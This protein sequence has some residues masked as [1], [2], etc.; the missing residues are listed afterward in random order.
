[1]E[2]LCLKVLIEEE[3]ETV[4]VGFYKQKKIKFLVNN[5]NGFHYSLLEGNLTKKEWDNVVL[6]HYTDDYKKI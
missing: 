2:D 5:Y 3:Y 1:M 6:L 4:Y